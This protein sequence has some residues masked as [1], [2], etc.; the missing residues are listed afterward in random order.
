MAQHPKDEFAR[1]MLDFRM[2]NDNDEPQRREKVIRLVLN[3]SSPPPIPNEA[4]QDFQQATAILQSLRG[5]QSS[6]A[7]DLEKPINLLGKALKLAPWWANAYYNL[8]IADELRGWYDDAITQLNYYLELQ[9]SESDAANARAKIAA[10][11]SE[12][13]IAKRKQEERES[14][15][16]VRYVGGGVSRIHAS[17]YSGNGDEP[18]WWFDSNVDDVYLYKTD[19]ESPFYVNAFRFPNGHILVIILDAQSNNG[20][21]AGDKIAVWDKTDDSCREGWSNVAFDSDH[22]FTACGFH[23]SISVT[24]PPNA[25][26][27]VRDSSG[28]SISIPLVNLYRGR[29]LLAGTREGKRL[30]Q[31]GSQWMWLQFDDRVVQAAKDPNVNAMGLTPTTV[32]PQ[33]K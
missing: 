3:M 25:L 19:E 18:K 26:V 11:E 28:A 6:S 33:S 32:T 8:A 16:S 14:M 9:P 27:L 5:N 1:T 21:Y 15:L 12:K 24:S 17:S 23:Y 2:A 20:A 7:D 29:A 30:A 31:P 10:I 13:E 4:K 22:S